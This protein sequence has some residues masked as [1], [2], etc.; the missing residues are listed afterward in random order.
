[1]ALGLSFPSPYFFAILY[2]CCHYILYNFF[3][4]ILFLYLIWFPCDTILFEHICVNILHLATCLIGL[5]FCCLLHFLFSAL[6]CCSVV[7]SLFTLLH[8]FHLPLSLDL[9]LEWKKNPFSWLVSYMFINTCRKG[10]GAILQNHGPKTLQL[11]CLSLCFPASEKWMWWTF[12]S[13]H[14]TPFPQ[15]QRALRETW[16]MMLRSPERC[17]PFCRNRWHFPQLIS[18]KESRTISSPQA[19]HPKLTVWLQDH[20]K[21]LVPVTEPKT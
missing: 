15:V 1:M 8:Q 2:I 14:F 12:S 18:V 9:H 13:Q 11:R 7:Y 6:L 16:Q 10:W 17:E 20:W 3:H 5:I 19:C 4:A 21:W